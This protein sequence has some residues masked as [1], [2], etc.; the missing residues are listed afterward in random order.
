[1]FGR[2]NHGVEKSKVNG[3]ISRFFVNP[4]RRHVASRVRLA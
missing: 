4:T 1:L 3:R 2:K